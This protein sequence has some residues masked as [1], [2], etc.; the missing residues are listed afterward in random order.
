MAATDRL[1]G[2]FPYDV[3]AS[4]KKQHGNAIGSASSKENAFPTE[5]PRKGAM[6]GKEKIIPY[7]RPS[8][9]RMICTELIHSGSQRA[10]H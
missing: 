3:R 4:Y 6:E 8:P 1:A 10:V 9:A 5:P 7:C 2:C